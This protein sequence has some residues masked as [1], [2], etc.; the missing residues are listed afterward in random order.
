MSDGKQLTT[1]T[2]PV[3][4]AASGVVVSP[5]FSGSKGNCTLIQSGSVNI[6]LDAGFSY[7]SILHALAERGLTPKDIAAI[8]ITHEHTDHIAALPY[9][10]KNCA[11][12][13]YAP[14]PIADY[15]RQRVYFSEVYEI[16]GSFSIGDISVDVYECSHDARSC[17][18][19]RFSAG[20]G[21]F[22]CVTDTGCCNDALI[23]FL[24]PCAA[25]MLE[26]NHDVNMLVK[27]EYSYVLKQ[28]ILSP[29][30]HLSNAQAADIVQKLARSRIKTIILAHLSE[31]NNTKEIAFNATVEA[32][33]SCGLVEGRDVTVYVADQYKN[34]VTVCVD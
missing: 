21:Y 11:T 9:W 17:C 6:L 14:A 19:Y 25:I 8:V 10:G 20:G 24:S 7:K 3:A 2:N 15:L 23:D 34:E 26:S 1:H 4:T 22:A 5:L 16:E 29:Y 33:T 28:R 18:G 12:P 13:I 31:K 27:G 30:G 32:L